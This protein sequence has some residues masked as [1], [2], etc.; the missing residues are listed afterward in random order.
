MAFQIG[1]RSPMLNCVSNPFIYTCMDDS[2]RKELKRLCYRMN[3]EDKMDLD[4]S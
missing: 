2:F 1:Y 4:R 3:L